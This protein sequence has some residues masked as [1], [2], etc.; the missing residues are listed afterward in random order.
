[1]KLKQEFLKE[2]E[3]LPGI[4]AEALETAL[5]TTVAPVS[6]RYNNRKTSDLQLND[7]VSWATGA[8]Y[9]A[10]RPA[11]TADPL[12]HAGCYY[13]QE[14]GSMFV[15]QA[16]RQHLDLEKPLTVLDLCAA[17]G[18]K[19][20][21]L[22]SLLKDNDVLIS[23]EINKTRAD[24]LTENIQKWGTP[25]VIVTRNKPA[26]FSPLTDLFDCIV[27]DAPCSGEGMFRKTPEAIEEWSPANVVQCAQ[28]QREILEDIWP[29]LKPGG[30]LIYSTC[31][32]NLTENEH[33]VEWMIDEFRADS[34]PLETADP[35]ITSS[36]V[37]GVEAARFFPHKTKA[38]GFFLSVLQKPEGQK[39]R[40]RKMKPAIN[41]LTR[42]EEQPLYG[43]LQPNDWTFFSHRSQVFAS[44]PHMTEVL[45][46]V[47]AHLYPLHI[48]VPIGELKGTDLIPSP[49]LAFSTVLSRKKFTVIEVTKDQALALLSRETPVLETPVTGWVLVT[50]Q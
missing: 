3:A 4:D 12:F 43:I 49:A 46:R 37:L 7:P 20:T 41:T 8:E 40:V 38:E 25:N 35:A 9:L 39:A 23:N 45:E 42:K 19:S 10:K 11:F 34:L 50:F 30:L 2:A 1:M 36:L 18:G 16:I 14:A 27:V 48:G 15:E 44:L 31:T 13:V 26:D 21:H 47:S 17:P 33:Q 29:C 5:T 24:I 32:F 22:A 28:R 6:I